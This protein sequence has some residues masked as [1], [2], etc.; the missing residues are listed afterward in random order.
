MKREDLKA[1]E[2]SDE[3]IEKIMKLHGQDVEDS[4][5]KLAQAEK[6]TEG[7]K[8]QLDEANKV[9]KGFEGLDVAGIKAAAADWEAKA[10]Q[11]KEEAEA[12]IAKLKF[13]N[14]LERALGKAEVKDADTV[15]PKLNLEN[16]KLSD[17]E[18]SII[19][20][21]DQLKGLKETHDY[22]FD[23]ET[24]TPQIVGGSKQ[25]T[26][27]SGINGGTLSDAIASKMFPKG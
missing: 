4:K 1:L 18:K 23:S 12:E 21:D 6:E 3:A 10:N 5:S 17:D 14:A 22:L 15:I 13:N 24:P 2:I 25:Q 20:L 7:L 27:P 11:A 16:I 26:T 19:G 9:I 8:T